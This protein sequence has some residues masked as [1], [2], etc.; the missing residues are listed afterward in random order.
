MAWGLTIVRQISRLLGCAV[1]VESEAGRGTTFTVH[2]PVANLV[3]P[4]T[5]RATLGGVTVDRAGVPKPAVLVIEDDAAVLDAL[6]LVLGLEGYPI[7]VA[8][9]AAAAEAIFA[10]HGAE[11]DVVV[12]DYHLGDGR[13][14]L[15]LL[16]KLRA[17]ASRDLPAVIL[18]GDTS[19]VLA[20]IE[21]VS[22]VELLRKPVDARQLILMLE[23]LFG[24]AG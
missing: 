24:A 18:S 16:E 19:S 9:S 23:E 17:T 13:N 10:R 14:G 5:R 8:D 15:E 4:T 12:S 11:I 3:E 2:I 1:K 21:S 20:S 6:E 7:R 22:R